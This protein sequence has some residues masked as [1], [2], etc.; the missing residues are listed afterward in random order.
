VIAVEII[1][2]LLSVNWIGALDSVVYPVSTTATMQE[3][4]KKL[5]SNIGWGSNNIIKMVSN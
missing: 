1:A 4:I 3:L 5:L 2:T